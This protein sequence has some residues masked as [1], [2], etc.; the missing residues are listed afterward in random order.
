[1]IGWLSGTVEDKIGRYL[2]LNVNGVGYRVTVLPE[3]LSRSVPS[4]SL[5]LYI[6][7]HV[8]EDA[9]DLYG[10]GDKSELTLFEL[11]LTVSGIGP[12]TALGILA[13]MRIEE[14]VSAISRGDAGDFSGISGLG[15]KGAQR[16]IVEL[17]T[18]IGAVGDLD[19]SEAGLG[20]RDQIIQALRTFGFTERECRE[21][22]KKVPS[23]QK[24]TL[25]QKIKLTLKNLGH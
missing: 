5:K 4:S 17:R 10:F 13:G 24:F 22:L 9:F 6:H 12:K 8:K 1:M 23:D 3:T 20:E 25:E 16:I 2:I 14:I 7:P 21:A 15:T 18:K 19:L 11:L